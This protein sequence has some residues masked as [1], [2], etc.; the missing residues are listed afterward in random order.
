M[1]KL[2]RY[3]KQKGISIKDLSDL[4]G[5]SRQTIWLLES[6]KFR[7]PSIETLDKIS[8]VLEVS[9]QELVEMLEI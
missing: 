9:R 8:R 7:N 4:S 6:G 1:N 5:I 3:R 2:K